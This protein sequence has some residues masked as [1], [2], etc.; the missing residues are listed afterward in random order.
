MQTLIV[1]PVP[2]APPFP[3]LSSNQNRG[4][5]GTGQASG[6]LISPGLGGIE[7]G[8]L[9]PNNGATAMSSPFD[10]SHD[11]SPG[12]NSSTGNVPGFGLGK[13]FGS[14]SPSGSSTNSTTMKDVKPH[15]DAKILPETKVFKKL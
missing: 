13:G 6:S 12:T 5:F 10:L 4:A 14:L 9:R 8:G 1:H 11:S 2:V 7:N 3:T 15:F